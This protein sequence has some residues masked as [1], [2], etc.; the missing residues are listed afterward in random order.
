MGIAAASAMWSLAARAGGREG[1]GGRV[2]DL[3]LLAQGGR[4]WVVGGGGLAAGCQ[5]DRAGT[6]QINKRGI[7][8]VDTVFVKLLDKK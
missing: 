2:G 1:G 5:G 4:W 7:T 8:S 6:N 3:G